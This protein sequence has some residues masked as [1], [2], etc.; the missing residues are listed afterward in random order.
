MAERDILYSSPASPSSP[1]IYITDPP[2]SP[3][4]PAPSNKLSSSDAEHCPLHDM[5]KAEAA[6]ASGADV[7]EAIRQHGVHCLCPNEVMQEEK[8][9][10]AKAEAAASLVHLNR[11]ANAEISAVERDP[12]FVSCLSPLRRKNKMKA[13][14][15]KKRLTMAQER[16]R[17]IEKANFNLI[18]L[19]DCMGLS[20][21]SGFDGDPYKRE[22]AAKMFRHAL[23]KFMA[24][25]NMAVNS[26]L[27]FETLADEKGLCAM[28]SAL[29][30]LLVDRRHGDSYTRANDG[31]YTVGDQLCCCTGGTAA[32]FIECKGDRRDK[33]VPHSLP[34]AYV[35][36]LEAAPDQDDTGEEEDDGEEE[37]VAATDEVMGL[38]PF[39]QRPT[40]VSFKQPELPLETIVEE[41]PC[42][43]QSD[44]NNNSSVITITVD[45]ADEIEDVAR[46]E[47]EEVIEISG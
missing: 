3:A 18:D 36:S 34:D 46:E 22:H 20:T 25:N 39:K 11:Q 21:V 42:D 28:T 37:E 6:L 12:R 32:T 19:A 10:A 40:V 35:I 38:T 7:S 41:G 1:P 47:E 45:G 23:R 5:E 24:A 44:I 17:I 33:L 9:T 13:S 43:L 2:A 31:V 14:R 8:K 15:K 4:S 30:M 26:L 27:L 16:Q 29:N